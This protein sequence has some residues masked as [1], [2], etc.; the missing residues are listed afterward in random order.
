[1]QT[2]TRCLGMIKASE[3]FRPTT[4]LDV[5]GMPTVGYGHC[6]VHPESFPNGINEQQASRLLLA[7]VQDAERALLRM[8]KV[9]LTQGQFD[10]LVDFVFNLG[11]GR[12]HS[13]MLLADSNA[14]R[15]DA[16]AEQ[17]LL[18]DHVGAQENPGLKARRQAEFELFTGHPATQQ[19]PSAQSVAA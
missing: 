11:S 17:I 19:A 10:A 2:S 15:M 3:G 14:G 16:A 4:Y 6:L 5:N 1:M 8:V 12:L 9:P 18:W 7:D 13:S